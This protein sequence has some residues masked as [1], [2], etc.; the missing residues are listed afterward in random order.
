MSLPVRIYVCESISYLCRVGKIDHHAVK[1]R[2]SIQAGLLSIE[3]YDA[4]SLLAKG[5]RAGLTNP[6]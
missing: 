3:A 5:I 4:R 1:H 6:T 2:V